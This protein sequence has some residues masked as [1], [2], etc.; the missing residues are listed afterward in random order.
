MAVLV[1]GVEATTINV[2][3]DHSTIQAAINAAVNN[4][5]VIVAASGGP[6]KENIT[7]DGTKTI[8]VKTTDGAVIDGNKNGSVVSF[9][10]GDSSAIVG[11]TIQGGL[12]TSGAGILC[13]ESSSPTITNCTI[14]GNMATGAGGGGG[15]LCSPS[16]S[17]TIENCV[18]SDN[19]AYRQGGG[20][21]CYSSSPT[22]TNCTISGNTADGGGGGIDCY[23]TSPSITG[24]TISGNSA[25]WGGGIYCNGSSPSMRNCTISGN[26]AYDG[27]GGAIYCNNSSPPIINCTI[28]G[29]SAAQNGGG[30]YCGGNSPPGA[31]IIV[32]SVFWGN[33]AGENQNEIYLEGTNSINITYSD[34]QQSSGIY[35][36]KENINQEPLFVNPVNASNA[37]TTL[38]NYH[39]QS[40]STCIDTGTSSGTPLYDIDRQ[41]RPQDGDGNNIPLYDMGSDEYC[42]SPLVWYKDFDGDGYSDGATLTQCDRS[43]N[44]YLST[45]LAA[46]SGDCDDDIAKINPGVAEICDGVNND[47]DDDIDEECDNDGDDYCDS[48]MTV[49]GK[50]V[51]CPHGKG[52]C[53]DEVAAIHPGMAEVCDGVDNNCAGGIDEGGNIL[54]ADGNLCNG[55][56]TCNGISECQAGTALNCNDTN[57]CTDDSCDPLSGCQYSNNTGSCDDSDACTNGD[58]C[59]GGVCVGGPPPIE[60]CNDGVDNDCD[61]LTDGFDTGCGVCTTNATQSCKT[62]KSGVCADGTQTC[63]AEGNWGGCV[64][65]NQPSNEICDGLDNDCDNDIDEALGTTTCGIMACEVEVDN[66][67]NG[68]PQYCIPEE[69]CNGIVNSSRFEVD[70]NY[71]KYPIEICIVPSDPIDLGDAY[72]ILENG[73]GTLENINGSDLTND[74]GIV[75]P[76][77]DRG[78]FG[79]NYCVYYKDE[80]EGEYVDIQFYDK[81]EDVYFNM[82]FYIDSDR[83]K[84]TTFC[85]IND[86]DNNHSQLNEQCEEKVKVKSNSGSLNLGNTGLGQ[87][88]CVW[89]WIINYDESAIPAIP[90]RMVSDCYIV[91][92]RAGVSIATGKTIRI[93]MGFTMPQNWDKENFENNLKVFYYDEINRLWRTDG[94]YVYSVQWDSENAG[95]IGFTASHLTTFAAASSEQDINESDSDSTQALGG[96]GGGGCSLALASYDMPTSSAIANILLLLLPLIFFKSKTKKHTKPN[97]S[98]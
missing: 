72:A 1:A 65:N 52:D 86:E 91:V 53:N 98:W 4:D 19:W 11:F 84:S 92:L 46:T 76:S 24:C 56:E 40:G 63:N 39:L 88:D 82:N 29:N 94:I 70:I 38:G 16:S 42:A 87:S 35:T 5:E 28:S 44:Y 33:I 30:I 80:M 57:P 41:P 2:P 23:A 37:P 95:T 8:I 69:V 15:I 73:N 43:D 71:N 48:R 77:D 74:W 7:F 66:C 67:F 93:E 9:T 78:C 90:G 54:C 81:A 26:I 58:V 25:P 3:G 45:E 89:T 83:E 47:C 96:G 18:I 62:G 79:Y 61:G 36:G 13:G 22:I 32:N 27:G 59:S 68:Q 34:V 85:L 55:T 97:G 51:V 49:V 75:Q 31:F 17:P 14:S 21:R 60:I 10:G 12:A 50:P 6:Y 20:I 64:Q